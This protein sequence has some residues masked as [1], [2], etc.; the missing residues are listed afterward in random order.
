MDNRIFIN[1]TNHP[2]VRWSEQQKD[3]SLAYGE[4]TDI[5]FPLISPRASSNEIREMALKMADKIIA[6]KPAAVLCQGEF[7]Y[8]FCLVDALLAHG[9]RVMS[10]CSERVVREWK[11]ENGEEHRDAVFR[12]QQYRDYLKAK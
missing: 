7:N 3:A 9:I 5:P 1:H 6:M 4:I 8:V 12:F 11:D 10:A 2:S